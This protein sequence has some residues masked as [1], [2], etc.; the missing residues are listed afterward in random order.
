MA[1]KQF[2]DVRSKGKF[3]VELL[4]LTAFCIIGF[5]LTWAFIAYRFS[6]IPAPLI[7]PPPP[8][9]EHLSTAYYVAL[10]T[11]YMGWLLMFNMTA[12]G[13]LNRWYVYQESL[14]K[15]ESEKI[16]E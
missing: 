11:N 2:R 7:E 12:T 15:S 6:N 16:E 9:I 3:S 1:I 13:W 4:G 5:L 10:A 8:H 14:R